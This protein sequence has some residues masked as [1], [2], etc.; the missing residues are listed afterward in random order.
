ML[1]RQIEPKV[2]VTSSVRDECLALCA[3]I[4]AHIIMAKFS[5]TLISKKPNRLV[6]RSGLA[7]MQ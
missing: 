1:L 7:K 5:Q 3:W 2:E 6:L 4:S